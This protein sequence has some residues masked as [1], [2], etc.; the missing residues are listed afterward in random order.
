[1]KIV[2][3]LFINKLKTP[4]GKI[5]RN[6]RQFINS[7]SS[8]DNDLF[9]VSEPFP[10]KIQSKDLFNNKLY[11]QTKSTVIDDF[12]KNHQPGNCLCFLLLLTFF[13]LNIISSKI[14]ETIDK[15]K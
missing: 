14:K 5:F 6:N 2:K 8:I 10:E 9:K 7:T 1:M 3:K 4:I 11:N 13:Y 15:N 12:P